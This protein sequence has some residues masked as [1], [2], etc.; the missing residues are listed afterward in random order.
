[1]V[2]KWLPSEGRWC[3]GLGQKMASDQTVMTARQLLSILRLSQVRARD[4]TWHEAR[5][6]R[7]SCSAYTFVNLY[8][9]DAWHS[10]VSPTSLPHTDH[11]CR[12][13]YDHPGRPN[14]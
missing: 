8:H 11:R 10:P 3:R 9:R 6:N 5:C 12:A 2:C 7:F 1:V 14:I 4:T 13:F